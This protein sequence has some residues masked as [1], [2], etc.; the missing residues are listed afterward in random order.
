M[1][2]D[3]YIIKAITNRYG[4][5]AGEAIARLPFFFISNEDYQS[6][7]NF[8]FKWDDFKGVQKLGDLLFFHDFCIYIEGA[9]WVHVIYHDDFTWSFHRC[10]GRDL[11][12]GMVLLADEVDP[13]DMEMKAYN[14][15]YEGLLVSYES[16][17]IIPLDESEEMS[18]DVSSD[19]I[20][21]KGKLP[22]RVSKKSLKQIHAEIQEALKQDE[23]Y[24]TKGITQLTKF[25]LLFSIWAESKHR[26]RVAPV[27]T[28]KPSKP[29]IIKQKPW[30]NP[31]RPHYIFVDAP[32]KDAE[33]ISAGDEE[34][35]RTQRRGHHRRACWVHLKHER[36][37]NHPMYGKRIRRRATWVGPVEWRV[38][39]TIYTLDDK[40]KEED[41]ED[42]E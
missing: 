26:V 8:H 29:H 39:D 40:P 41:I 12:K 6:V 27:Q 14:K 10:I 36:Y 9:A 5:E 4:P 7:E 33:Y 32:H 31:D 30:L 19:V 34:K 18:S 17:M 24:L 21:F 1:R 28:R 3:D 37:K 11:K 23:E 16:K 13:S 22:N 2:H 20:A 38:K 25:I 15:R 42:D 35:A